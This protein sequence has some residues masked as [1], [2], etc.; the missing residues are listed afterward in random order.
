MSATG[1]RSVAIPPDAVGFL[2]EIAGRA[3]SVHNT[4][5]WRFRLTRDGT[6]ELLADR[7]RQLQHT[8]PQGRELHISC[9]AALF[10]LRLAIQLKGYEPQVSLLPDP[11]DK[12]VLARARYGRVRPVQAEDRA[13]LA[14]LM[15]RHTHRGAFSTEPLTSSLL[16][17]L[18]QVTAQEGAAL[19]VIDDPA[20]RRVL[21]G[22]VRD[23]DQRQRRDPAVR[24]ELSAWTPPPGRPRRD[25]VPATAYPKTAPRRTADDFVV[26]DFSQ[27]RDQ[28]TLPLTAA[29]GTSTAAVLLTPG[30]A[31]GDWLA[32]G[33][34]LQHALLVAA[35]QWV[36]AR[37]H[38]Q[39]LQLPDLRARLTDRL[40]LPGAAQMLLTLGHA[41]EAPTT[42]RRP[43][44][45]TVTSGLPRRRLAPLR[46]G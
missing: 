5:P 46:S 19:A 29:R 7:A 33:A 24:A 32:A 2:A 9:G 35:Q 28:G 14:A 4:Q 36:F 21:S 20:S 39:P 18:R 12:D 26:R 27:G 31:P 37:V 23:A 42:P 34:A 30:D 22:L 43:V 16:A 3:P 17:T 38:S 15:R 41:H 45:E 8:D 40:A 13:L 11:T 1:S 10:G 6:L 25:G 44:S